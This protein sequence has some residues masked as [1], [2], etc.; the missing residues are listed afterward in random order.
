MP[1]ID[2]QI[3]RYF[4]AFEM[5]SPA[6]RMPDP[7]GFDGYRALRD[8]AAASSGHSEAVITGVASI[9]SHRIVTALFDF[10]FLGGS[11]SVGV[12]DALEDATKHATDLGL[13]FLLVTA[14]GGARMQEGMA[15][16]AQMPRTVAATRRLA[17]ASLPRISLLGDPTTGGVYA[18][19]AS[20][21]D[22]IVATAGATVGFAGPRVVRALTGQAL[23]DG[24]HTSEAALSAGLVDAVIDDGEQR[25]YLER[26]LDVISADEPSRDDSGPDPGHEPVV[27][28]GLDAWESYHLARHAKRPSPRWY[29]ERIAGPCIELHGD[30]SGSDDDAVFIKIG[31]IDGRRVVI[32]GFD[33]RHPGASGFRKAR[34]AI[35]LASS[36]GWPLV[37]LIDTPGADPMSEY[38]GLAHEI[39]LTFAEILEAPVPTMCAVTGEGG[40][41]GALTLACTDRVGIQQN[42][43]FSVIAPEGAAVILHRDATRASGLAYKLNPTSSEMVRLGLADSLIAEDP[44]AHE[45]PAK[46][47]D[48]L[49]VWLVWALRT[50]LA[51]QAK[52]VDRYRIPSL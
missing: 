48:D 40:S 8:A 29:A 45:D 11:M 12:G 17:R 19:I 49:G 23:P 38:A 3:S 26:L 16:L 13:A 24:S 52:R 44:P 33:R 51:D 7:I 6:L 14:T 46:A 10:N 42:A 37:T 32:T 39:A 36:W 25:D 9:G 15:A 30:R 4:D 47:A 27:P 31:R 18:S 20:L 34:R 41:G 2:E 21:S 1:L 28:N 50:T 43:V 35:A 22:I 5:F